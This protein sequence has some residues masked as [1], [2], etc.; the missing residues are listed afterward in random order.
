MKKGQSLLEFA[1]TLPLL[2]IIVSGVF[3]LGRLYFTHIAMEDGVGEAALYVSI[4]PDCVTADDG[5]QCSYPDNAF[6]RAKE[7]ITIPFV[8]ID[9]A[10]L[11]V[12]C[13]SN[14]VEIDCKDTSP[15][16]IAKITMTYDYE[17]LTPLIR[18]IN[19]LPSITLKSEATTLILVP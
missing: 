7:S 11:N 3:D 10:N 18:K 13:L 1:I 4:N 8:N 6:D 2:L 9:D 5:P 17:L 12:T 14:S 16:D 19:S 15:G